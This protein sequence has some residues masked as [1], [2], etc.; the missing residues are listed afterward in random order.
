MK[1]TVSY[2]LSNDSDSPYQMKVI[3]QLDHVTLSWKSFFCKLHIFN[4]T[5]VMT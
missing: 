3:G 2:S 1:L 4:V 5:E